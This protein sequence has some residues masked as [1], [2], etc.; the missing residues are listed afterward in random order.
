MR[1]LISFFDHLNVNKK[2]S[3][4]FGLLLGILIIQA[5][6]SLGL[7]HRVGSHGLTAAT[8]LAPQAES[9]ILLEYLVAE[10]HRT[11]EEAMSGIA[12]ADEETA[13]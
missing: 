8:E 7:L 2:L 12:G 6:L 5:G 13:E 11:T 3:V 1:Q 4:F 9:A 10:A